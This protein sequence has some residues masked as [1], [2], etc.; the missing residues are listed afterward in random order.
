VGKYWL[1]TDVLIQ[2]KNGY[3][4]FE[5]ARQF[6]DFLEEQAEVDKVRSS[7]R[8][9]GE[10]MRYEDKDDPLV[11]WAKPRKT[12]KLF[13]SPDKDVQIV[14]GE[15]GDHVLKYYEQRLAAVKRFL[16][17]ADPWII[18]HAKCDH[19]TVVSHES[20][21]ARNALIPKIP[22]VCHAFGVGCIDLPMM[23][24]ALKFKFGR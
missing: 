19:G 9:Y 16:D 6:W 5:I 1:D 2:A 7:I 11:K 18:A 21:L 24:K 8:V 23:L 10:I 20:R 12:S 4:S 15:I 17:G 22:N 14:C 13:C 3:Y